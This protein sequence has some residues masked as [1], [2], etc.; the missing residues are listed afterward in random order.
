VARYFGHCNRS[1]TAPKWLDPSTAPRKG[2]SLGL[3]A[4]PLLVCSGVRQIG[5]LVELI[6]SP[7]GSLL[8]GQEL[9]PSAYSLPFGRQTDGKL[10]RGSRS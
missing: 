8:R 4:A 1:Q 9:S 10:G 7:Q 5:A 3:I 2:S 6:P